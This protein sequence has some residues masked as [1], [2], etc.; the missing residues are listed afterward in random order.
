M[1]SEEKMGKI[2]VINVVHTEYDWWDKGP[3]GIEYGLPA[4]MR[5][6]ERLEPEE[7]LKI[8]ITWCLFFANNPARRDVVDTHRE[9]FLQRLK[10][11]DEVGVHTHAP[12]VRD[13]PKYYKSNAEKLEAAGFPYPK[14]HAPGW[15]YLNSEALHRLEEANIEI[16]A[17][18][19]V[20]EGRFVHP[21]QDI[22]LQ[23][24][25]NRDPKK[26]ASFRPYHPSRHRV[27]E[28]G[29]SPI[30]EIP[31]FFPLRGREHGWNCGPGVATEPHTFVEAFDNHWAHRKEVDVDIVQ[32]Y[33]H[34]FELV[35]RG[36]QGK[37]AVKLEVVRNL[38]DIFRHIG[39]REDVQF[40]TAH[41][42]VSVWKSRAVGV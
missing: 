3:S 31:I 41:A 38:C 22:L 23:D 13:Q 11:G 9:F 14:T 42:A 1:T 18:L 16:D 2:F 36:R 15:F 21:E 37:E 20:R 7:S 8:P 4:L 28:V 12:D 19:V 29:D 34:P 40:A 25:S 17:G 27:S 24:C 32:F 6:L 33:W 26:A 30:V 5:E 39:A 10:L 35:H